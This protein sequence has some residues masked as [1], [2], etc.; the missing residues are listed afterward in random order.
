M[1]GLA[2][3]AGGIGARLGLDRV[4]LRLG[5]SW[6]LGSGG[7]GAARAY[8]VRRRT[9]APFQIL[10][11]H[12]VN[13]SEDPLFDTV[14]VRVFDGQMALLRRRFRVLS[15][16][17]LVERRE[18][19]DVPPNAVAITFDD[20][21]RDNFENA[22]PILRRHGLPATV[23]LTSATVGSKELLWHDRLLDAFRE[24][25]VASL[26]VD[27]ETLPLRTPALRRAAV[28]AC[29]RGLRRMDPRRRD[30]E[31]ARLAAALAVA[32]PDERRWSKLTWE[33]VRE[34]AG[35][36]ISFGAHT[37]NHPILTRIPREEAVREIL[38]SRDAIARGLGRPVSLFAYPNG[39]RADFDEGVKQAVRDAGF[40]C[41]VT[42]IPGANDATTD[43]FE[44]R[45]DAMWD[46]VPQLAVM[47]L[48]WSKLTS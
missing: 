45:R 1:G 13:D 25:K 44:L 7:D 46:P 35:G 3:L 21:Y 5:D 31:V 8:G 48:A 28:Y 23:F 41:A 9:S 36:G 22:F 27:G 10:L 34:M 47:R 4:L 39:G 33:E 2:R 17:E 19:N 11:Y 42:A 18:R 40:R 24:T 38:D 15:L 32:E 16:D 43:P 6:R 30:E 29:L 12:R 37:A 26:D 20:G 14:S